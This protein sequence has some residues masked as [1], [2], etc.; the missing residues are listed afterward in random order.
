MQILI[1]THS[2]TFI[3]QVNNIIGLSDHPK[4]DSLLEELD[5]DEFEVISRDLVVAYD[6]RCEN[7]ATTVDELGLTKTGFI[8]SSLNDVL[9]RLAKETVLINRDIAD[10]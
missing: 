5:I 6:F 3:Q 7:G 10:I 1:T 8:P 9:I 4:R 2:D